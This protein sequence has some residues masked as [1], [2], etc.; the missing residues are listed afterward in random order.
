MINTFSDK[1]PPQSPEAEQYVLGAM[2]LDRDI[3]PLVAGILRHEDFA[4]PAH[5]VIFQAL[6]NLYE[7][8][9][10]IDL[11]AL[12]EEL[13][14]RNELESAGGLEY[15]A[16][17]NSLVPTSAG[18]EYH[19]QIVKEKS[20]LR[21]LI[22][23]SQQFARRGYD[24]REEAAALLG[25]A[26]QR[27]V[28][29]SQRGVYKPFVSLNDILLSIYE[30]IGELQEQGGAPSGLRTHFSHLDRLLG[31]L[32]PGDLILLAARPAMGK[33][34][35][36]M[37]IAQNVAMGSRRPVAVFSLEMAKEQLVLRMLSAESRIDSSR[38]K[39]GRLTEEEWISLT[40]AIGKLAEAPLF[41]DDTPSITVNQMR[42][43]ARHLKAERGDLALVVVD[44]LQL[45][46]PQQRGENRTQEI[47]EIS[48][49]LK[50]LAREL[51]VPVLALSQL[52]R[53]VEQT[54]DKKPN[55]SHLRESG[56]LEQ[57]SDIVLFIY[58]EDYYFPDSE[59]QNIADI[60]VAKHRNGP[61]GTIELYFLKEA[62][63][64]TTLERNPA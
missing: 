23:I 54:S 20:L 10:P 35:L 1:A 48:R 26:E 37:N 11:I 9:A 16:Y 42:A 41:I 36:A 33:T 40:S 3:V 47:S 59:K 29:I 62:T 51:N 61:T 19:A 39:A 14:R 12:S 56:A 31:G 5:R 2:M 22:D 43:K 18:V 30:R 44:Y 21:S 13:K 50:S 7:Q 63:R 64:F 6:N 17:L 55:L 34:S 15:I 38:L 58:R 25:E 60:I 27:I 45:M 46:Q 52:S 8:K 53:A 28:E 57:D 49:S 32:Q 4:R 24:A